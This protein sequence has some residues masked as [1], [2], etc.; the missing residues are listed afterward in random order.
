M[1]LLGA[2]AAFNK[3]HF[4]VRDF[5]G[6]FISPYKSACALHVS[7]TLHVHTLVM[8]TCALSQMLVSWCLACSMTVECGFNHAISRAFEDESPIFARMCA[9]RSRA[10]CQLPG[11]I[12]IKLYKQVNLE[13]F[14][15]S[16]DPGRV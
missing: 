4:R 11:R 1:C 3:S 12:R 5:G 16:K 6:V 8:T 10:Q 14:V 7:L 15:G 9:L 13:R 2:Q